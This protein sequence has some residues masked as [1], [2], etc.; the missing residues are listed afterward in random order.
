[1]EDEIS[2]DGK[3]GGSPSVTMQELG[4][5][6]ERVRILME[7]NGLMAEQN[8]V[9]SKE[10]RECN[11]AIFRTHRR[12]NNPSVA[13][14]SSLSLLCHFRCLSSR[15]CKRRSCSASRTS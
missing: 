9:L 5:V 14:C 2:I 7:E 1:M 4:D 6:E 12:P 13:F 3:R 10:V 11:E 8:A 15:G